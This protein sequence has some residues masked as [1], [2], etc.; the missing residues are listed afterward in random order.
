MVGTGYILPAWS[1][2]AFDSEHL[3]F[4]ELKPRKLI[5]TRSKFQRTRLTLNTVFATTMLQCTMRE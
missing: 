3:G 2:T 4:I 1:A 5:I